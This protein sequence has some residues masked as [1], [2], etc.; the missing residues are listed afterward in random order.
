M[1]RSIHAVAFAFALPIVALT[2]AC[3]GDTSASVEPTDGEDSA[4]LSTSSG[5][6]GTFSIDYDETGDT[7]NFPSLLSSLTLK[8][9]GTF[10]GNQDREMFFD[11]GNSEWGTFHTSGTYKLHASTDRKRHWITFSYEGTGHTEESWK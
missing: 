1:P 4:E 2:V 11:D 8:S 9:D 7:E 6:V 3:G 5:L 10:F